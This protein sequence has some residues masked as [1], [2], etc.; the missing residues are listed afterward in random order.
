MSISESGGG[1][2]GV[3][4]HTHLILPTRCRTS[5]S[6]PQGSGKNLKYR[7]SALIVNRDTSSHHVQKS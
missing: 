4:P 1:K 2:I 7:F 6:A 3:S 5:T